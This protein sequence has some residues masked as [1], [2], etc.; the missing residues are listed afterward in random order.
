VL[1]TTREKSK[2][3]TPKMKKAMC[4]ILIISAFFVSANFKPVSATLDEVTILGFSEQGDMVYY[5]NEEIVWLT[6]NSAEPSK[7]MPCEKAYFTPGA[8][9]IYFEIDSKLMATDFNQDVVAQ[10]PTS[11]EKVEHIDALGRWL[12]VQNGSNSEFF[13]DFN[14]IKKEQGLWSFTCSKNKQIIAENNIGTG[15]ISLTNSGHLQGISNGTGNYQISNDGILC[16]G[17]NGAALYSWDFTKSQGLPKMDSY[18]VESGHIIGTKD[19][20][21]YF[22]NSSGSYIKIHDLTSYIVLGDIICGITPE[23]LYKAFSIPTLE[24]IT[25]PEIKIDS[26]WHVF[27]PYKNF[28][29]IESEATQC[30]I[31]GSH[32]GMPLFYTPGKSSAGMNQVLYQEGENLLIHKLDGSLT[33]LDIKA[34]A[35]TSKDS[36]NPKIINTSGSRTTILYASPDNTWH[37]ARINTDTGETIQNIPITKSGATIICTPKDSP[38]LV[39]ANPSESIESWTFERLHEEGFLNSTPLFVNSNP[40]TV[41]VVSPRNG[42]ILEFACTEF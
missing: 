18:K 37:L 1:I 7:T 19:G 42:E 10:I 3:A 16:V 21:N 29:V 34:L 31:I 28:V 9:S 24:E 30:L 8:T 5:A 40:K 36:P 25:M 41:L 32:N 2:K 38:F 35:Q 33:R 11:I 39:R 20:S 17:D 4:Y 6:K 14:L 13:F 26:P 23:K 27:K 15:C 12:I 22:I